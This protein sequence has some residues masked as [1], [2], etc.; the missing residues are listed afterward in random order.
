MHGCGPPAAGERSTGRAASAAGVAAGLRAY[1]LPPD[2]MC[3]SLSIRLLSVGWIRQDSL[4]EGMIPSRSVGWSVSA[5]N[6]HRLSACGV[7]SGCSCHGNGF[8]CCCRHC[9]SMLFALFRSCVG[10]GLRHGRVRPLLPGNRGGVGPVRFMPAAMGFTGNANPRAFRARGM[11]CDLRG[12]PAFIGESP[13]S[14]RC[15]AHRARISCDGFSPPCP[16]SSRR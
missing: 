10:T 2:V 16:G 5:A 14:R 4:L 8:P 11:G 15:R 1:G 7:P 6:L 3:V 13:T 9:S 12:V